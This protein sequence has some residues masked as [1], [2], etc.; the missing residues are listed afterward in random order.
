MICRVKPGNDASLWF[1]MNGLRSS[2]LGGAAGTG[3]TRFTVWLNACYVER[4]GGDGF[5]EQSWAN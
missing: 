3:G 5:M 4:E 1:D 2:L